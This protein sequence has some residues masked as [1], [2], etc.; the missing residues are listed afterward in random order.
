MITI[1]TSKATARKLRVAEAVNHLICTQ[2]AANTEFWSQRT[3]AILAELNADIAEALAM[4]QGNT[5]LGAALNATQDTLNVIDENGQAV[6]TA[7][8]PVEPGRT[9]IVFNGTAFVYVPPVEPE[10][11]PEP[12]AE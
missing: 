1:T 3:E 12:P 11:E 6:F 2:R 7:R 4:F 5:T 10:L 9:D 8:A